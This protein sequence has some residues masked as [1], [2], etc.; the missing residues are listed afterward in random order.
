MG[1]SIVSFKQPEK[2]K[3]YELVLC[4]LG[5]CIVMLFNDRPSYNVKEIM[6]ALNID[7]ETA[8]KNI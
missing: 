3:P 4:T 8:R 6:A 7:E 2:A 5:M 1:T